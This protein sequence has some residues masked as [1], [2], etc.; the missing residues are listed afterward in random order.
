M[1]SL[2]QEHAAPPYAANTSA[3]N[4]ARH[5]LRY[6]LQLPPLDA[7]NLAEYLRSD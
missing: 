6:A 1:D 3:F 2:Q 4:F 5:C 7:R